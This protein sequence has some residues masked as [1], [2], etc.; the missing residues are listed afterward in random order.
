MLA[1]SSNPKDM[2]FGTAVGLINKINDDG[3]KPV[4]T[5]AGEIY[6][7][8]VKDTPLSDYDFMQF[9]TDLDNHIF[10]AK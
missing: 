2:P 7:S 8:A 4:L 6:R 5:G 10:K 1:F 3:Y 9:S